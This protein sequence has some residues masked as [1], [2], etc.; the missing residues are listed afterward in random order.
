MKNFFIVVIVIVFLFDFTSCIESSPE[1]N[2]NE[3]SEVALN[4]MQNKYGISFNVTKSHILNP[5]FTGK[6]KYCQIDMMVAGEENGKEYMVEVVPSY[7]D[8]DN[9]GFYD[10]YTVTWELYWPYYHQTFANPWI[11]E[12][13][14]EYTN[15]KNFKSFLLFKESNF[16]DKP[17][18]NVQELLYKCKDFE[19]YIVVSEENVTDVDY[20]LEFSELVSYLNTLDIACEGYFRILS[21]EHFNDVS[22]FNTFFDYYFSSCGNA[23]ITEYEIINT[24]KE[25]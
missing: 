18:T 14:G 6:N 10:S 7:T 5:D 1:I 21:K 13:V 23:Y 16:N 4:F 17:P 25:E 20:E 11:E 9:D 24:I 12:L 3:V 8:L 15:F 19:F 2:I 22:K